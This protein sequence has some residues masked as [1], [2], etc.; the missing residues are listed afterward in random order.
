M[1]G[2]EATRLLFVLET[3]VLGDFSQSGWFEGTHE[4]LTWFQTPT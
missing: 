1:L 4:D 3:F 2:Y